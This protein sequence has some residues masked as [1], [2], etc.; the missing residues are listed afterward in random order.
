MDL[1][2]AG[3][4]RTRTGDR[5][6]RTPRTGRDDDAA[7]VT[8]GRRT[9][10]RRARAP[11]HPTTL[12]NGEL[13][14]DAAR[15]VE[16]LLV[17]LADEVGTARVERYFGAG[18]AKLRTGDDGELHV[19]A[20]NAFVADLIGRRFGAPLE[21]L[22]ARHLGNGSVRFGVLE[23]A[24]AEANTAATEHVA[25]RTAPEGT[26]PARLA[27][28]SPTAP[29]TR[30]AGPA[31][32]RF[33][34]FLVGESNRLAHRAA[35][36]L[37]AANGP[38]P[39]SPLF[40]H[41]ACGVGKSHLLQAIA[42]KQM[43]RLGPKRVR[44]L[45]AESFTN[46]FIWA[47]KRNTMAEFRAGFRGLEV[48]CIDDVHCLGGKQKTQDELLH[49]LDALTLERARI[50]LASDGH[51]RQ[52]GT[53]CAQLRSRFQSGAV[54]EVHTP[55]AELIRALVG[56]LAA[57][58]SLP[59]AP[60]AIELIAERAIRLGE[61]G[62][63]ASVRDVEGMVTQIEAVYRLLPELCAT[64]GRIGLT[65][66]RRALGLGESAA[67][68]GVPR[69][70]VTLALI[71]RE[72]SAAMGVEETELLGKGRHKR[73]VLAR[74]AIVSVARDLTTCSF[75]EIARC[76]GR[77]NHST[78]ITAHQRISAQIERDEPVAAG[79]DCDG[80]PVRELLDRLRSR[81][82]RAATAV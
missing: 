51:P 28:K 11:Q 9:A 80:S 26:K 47:I 59:I 37:A 72:V 31:L 77:S 8:P 1:R 57:E 66:T 36:E 55:D 52:I 13:A 68:T 61:A 17:A 54:V 22:A 45:T 48:L 62:G 24:S 4:Q 71:K 6:D 38:S 65:L 78:V 3:E 82:E 50:V 64:P 19:D 16:A 27:Q 74:A 75:P 14:A 41:G 7:Q 56:T 58:R 79:M 25:R 29:K 33:D 49:T 32:K 67:P 10:G 23:R 43:E 73:V 18:Q 5:D 53:L 30:R 15:S 46:S 35:E 2:L 44:Y 12:A 60:E 70:P 63:G 69:R 81:V 42:S 21:R 20:P 34:T 40:I 39:F 76:L